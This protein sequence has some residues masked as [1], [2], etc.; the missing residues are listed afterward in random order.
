MVTAAS[1]SSGAAALSA[2]S[3]ALYASR[4]RDVPLK[5]IL[6]SA[7]NV[8]S[9]AASNLSFVFDSKTLVKWAAAHA[10]REGRIGMSGVDGLELGRGASAEGRFIRQGP[11][12]TA[13][14]PPFHFVK[15]HCTDAIDGS[16]ERLYSKP[17]LT[18]GTAELSKLTVDDGRYLDVVPDRTALKNASSSH[19][20]PMATA[21]DIYGL[22]T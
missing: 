20:R 4:E 12:P 10:E 14:S 9:K 15:R 3:L 11:F 6:Q 19:H 7:A 5:V 22:N 21:H 8:A 17:V 13:I 1:L 2:R 16:Y 18:T